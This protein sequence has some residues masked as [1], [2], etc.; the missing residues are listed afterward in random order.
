[1]KSRLPL[2]CWFV[3]ITVATAWIVYQILRLAG[4]MRWIPG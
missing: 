4:A 3:G 2:V 1:M